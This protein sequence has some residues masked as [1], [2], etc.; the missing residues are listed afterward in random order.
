MS[1]QLAKRKLPCL[2]CMNATR[3]QFNSGVTLHNVGKAK[4][5]VMIECSRQYISDSHTVQVLIR[6]VEDAAVGIDT[7][8][9]AA[10]IHRSA[11]YLNLNPGNCLR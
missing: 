8:V 5:Q 4:A 7:A 2:K 9:K 6:S 10:L 1:K 3:C 11:L